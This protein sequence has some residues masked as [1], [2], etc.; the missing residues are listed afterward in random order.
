MPTDILGACPHELGTVL[1]KIKNFCSYWVIAEEFG[2]P[3]PEKPKGYHHWQFFL[4]LDKH[5]TWAWIHNKMPGV[6]VEQ[7]KGT[8]EE[9]MM[10]CMK[11]GNFVQGGQVIDRPGQG[12][13]TDIELFV[14]DCKD[15]T[16][17]ELWSKHPSQMV[18]Y[19]R[20]PEKVR[21]AFVTPRTKVTQIMWIFGPP[22]TGKTLYVDQY[23]PAAYRK[24]KSKWWDKYTGQKYVF[25]DE[26]NTSEFE[27]N[28]ILKIGN[29]DPFQV[30][31]K[32][33]YV[34][35]VSEVFVMVSNLEP[36]QVYQKE[37]HSN[38]DAICR[39]TVFLQA[40]KGAPH[41]I[42]LQRVRYAAGNWVNVG[43]QLV[44][45]VEYPD[46]VDYVPH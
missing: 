18:R 28:E 26:V 30:Q 8:V 3:T 44:R 21:A 39:R 37:F 25:M 10:Y 14:E 46:P 41:E 6:H 38:P 22:G 40:T 2:E 17:Q 29:K 19:H 36:Q 27:Y 11:D 33:G 43:P 7:R 12:A 23:Y 31:F 42:L 13:R 20:V 24:D 1:S 34:E 5:R 9:A 15:K 32:G 45:K 35:F 16:D 4:Q